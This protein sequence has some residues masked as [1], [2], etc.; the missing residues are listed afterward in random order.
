MG[1]SK[2]KPKQSQ[3][4]EAS[5]DT[6]PVRVCRGCGQDVTKEYNAADDKNAACP[7]V[8]CTNT[9]ANSRLLV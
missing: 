5:H 3:E 7:N 8:N 2:H 9:L 4:P 1:K 6:Q